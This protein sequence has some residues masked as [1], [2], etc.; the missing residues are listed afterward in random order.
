MLTRGCP[1]A[2]QA[3]GTPSTKSITA[4]AQSNADV[5]AL[6]DDL[7][8][9]RGRLLD[10]LGS[11]TMA[12]LWSAPERVY[13]RDVDYE[14][15]QDSDLLYLTGD[16][17]PDTGRSAGVDPHRA[18]TTLD[19]P[20]VRGGLYKWQRGDL[21]QFFWVLIK[22]SFGA[23]LGL[24]VDAAC[25]QLTLDL[26]DHRAVADEVEGRRP[27][28]R[29]RLEDGGG[30]AAAFALALWI[31]V[32]L[33]FW[34]APVLAAWQ[35][36]PAGKALFFSLFASLRNWSAFLVYLAVAGG[37]AA[38]LA[39]LIYNLHRLQAGAAIAPTIVFL[40]LVVAVPLYY[41]SLYASYR[42]VFP[43]EEARA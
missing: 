5:S 26:G 31:P 28:G 32:Q 33:A 15:R 14:Y 8:A 4:S 38:A 19:S 20:C 30:D 16:E 37:A 13:S 39:A 7:T 18:H 22:K 34:F 6:R 36:M 12:I 3:R 29:D 17:Q 23:D 9:R 41:A 27:Q 2:P 1:H 24:A 25:D 11:G 35:G 10:K 43:G 40:L 21:A 42:D